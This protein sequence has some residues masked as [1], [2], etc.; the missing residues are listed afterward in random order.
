MAKAKSEWLTFLHCS[1]QDQENL[2]FVITLENVHNL[3]SF[4]TDFPRLSKGN[5]ISPRRGF[6]F[7]LDST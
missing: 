6:T 5:G 2:Y 3:K 1:F 7:S 4:Y